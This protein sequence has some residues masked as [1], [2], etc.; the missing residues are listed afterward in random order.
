MFSIQRASFLFGASFVITAILG[1]MV[2]GISMPTMHTSMADAP[3]LLGVF[4][5]DVTHNIAHLLLGVW[6]LVAARSAKASI[7]FA[8]ISGVAYLV[9]AG[10]GLFLPDGM[11]LMVIGGADIALHT[12]L[13]VGLLGFGA[14]ELFRSPVAAA[15]PS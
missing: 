11:G 9:L 15:Q 4:P 7:A 2:T 5:V 6:G 1:F 3:R 8:M 12:V 13:A 10:I 14:R